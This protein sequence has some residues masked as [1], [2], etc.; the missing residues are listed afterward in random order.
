MTIIRKFPGKAIELALTSK[1][2]AGSLAYYQKELVKI[3]PKWDDDYVRNLDSWIDDIMESKLG[4]DLDRNLRQTT[5]QMRSVEEEVLDKLSILRD[6]LK[7]DFRGNE[8]AELLKSLGYIKFYEK[9]KDGDT[10]SLILFL[11]AFRNGM[12]EE[13][14]EKIVSAGSSPTQIEEIIDSKE[15]V[16]ESNIK[17]EYLKQSSGRLTAETTQTLNDLYD[18]IIGI[19]KIAASYYRHDPVKKREFTFYKVMARMRAQISRASD[20]SEDQEKAAS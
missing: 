19:C 14:K 18:E 7:V 20:E 12:T 15:E 13:T 6:Q 3:R 2:I 17:Q 1:T 9:A 4:L 8:I 5:Y 16:I 11:N 10:E